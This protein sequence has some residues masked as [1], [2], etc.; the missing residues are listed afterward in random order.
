MLIINLYDDEAQMS[1][2][3]KQANASQLL[4]LIDEINPFN[5]ITGGLM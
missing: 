5:A 2:F 3:I 4:K 1:A